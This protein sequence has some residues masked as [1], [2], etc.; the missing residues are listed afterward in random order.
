[1]VRIISVGSRIEEL[2]QLALRIF[3]LAMQ[4]QVIIE[5]EWI[6]GIK[7]SW[8]TISVGLLTMMI[9]ALTPLFLTLTR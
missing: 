7:M 2:Q 6:P 5:P 1:M 3:K 8:Q 9:G 4:Y